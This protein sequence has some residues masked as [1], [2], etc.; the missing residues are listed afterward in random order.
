MISFGSNNFFL[1]GEKN[2]L[3]EKS[4]C[5][6]THIKLVVIGQLVIKDLMATLSNCFLGYSPV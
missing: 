5:Y 3:K 6:S 1:G 2:S 4:C